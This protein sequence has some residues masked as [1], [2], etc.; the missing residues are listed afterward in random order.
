M[1]TQT[2]TFIELSDILTLKFTCDDCG[3]TLSIPVTR[4]LSK[5]EEMDKLA[6]CPMCRR[7]WTSHGQ[8]SYHPAIAGFL[9]GLNTLQLTLS[10]K[11]GFSLA[12]EIKQEDEDP[13]EA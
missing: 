13:P 11:L 7:F 10:K 3:C 9:T 2:Q 12:V 4:D 5:K 1:T 8:T 6:T